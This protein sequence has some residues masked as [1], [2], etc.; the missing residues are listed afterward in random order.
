MLITTLSE[1]EPVI[2]CLL[3]EFEPLTMGEKPV[4]NDQY[5]TSVLTKILRIVCFDTKDRSRASYH[6]LN[7][8]HF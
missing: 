6:S 3:V 4:S 7:D 5:E 8:G 2:V 1:C